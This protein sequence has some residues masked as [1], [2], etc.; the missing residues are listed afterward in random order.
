MKRVFISHPF[1]N[2]PK[3]NRECITA[4]FLALI[5]RDIMPISP[6]HMFSPLND[7]VPEER[8]LGLKFC[9]EMIPLCDAVFMCDIWKDSEGC[10]RE[11]ERSKEC[12]IPVYE[13]LSWRGDKPIF[14]EEM[15]EWWGKKEDEI[16]WPIMK[17]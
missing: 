14:Y 4:I 12:G 7:N 2:N 17:F 15:P 3:R 5:K 8:E 6:I 10:R 11:Y 16:K 13:I 9:E 1:H